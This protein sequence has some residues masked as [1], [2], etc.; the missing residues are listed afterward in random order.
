IIVPNPK[1]RIDLKQVRAHVWLA[2][3]AP[4]LSVTPAEWDRNYTRSRQPVA[5]QDKINR[6]LSLMENPS[7]ASL[8][9]NRPHSKSFASKPNSALLYSNPAAPQTSRAVAISSGPDNLH[10]PTSPHEFYRTGR[11]KAGSSAS[12]VLQAVVEA[13]NFEV[14]RRNSVQGDKPNFPR[15]ATF[16][17]GTR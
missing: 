12:L 13:D 11:E 8:M 1:K 9:L 7:S 10:S 5:S 17:E 2:P 3:H 15:S 6:R 14:S 16:Q 4:F